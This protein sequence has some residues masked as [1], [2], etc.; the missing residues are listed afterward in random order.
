MWA[1]NN[2]KHVYGDYAVV[3]EK[4]GKRWHVRIKEGG[5]NS[6]YIRESLGTD[7][8]AE[9]KMRAIKRYKGLDGTEKKGSHRTYIQFEGRRGSTRFQPSDWQIHRFWDGRFL[10]RRGEKR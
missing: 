1:E 6:G 7:D 5:A 10:G 8:L 9:A 3:V 4:R 2:G